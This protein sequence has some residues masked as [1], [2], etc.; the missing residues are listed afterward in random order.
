MD[1]KEIK[2]LYKFLKNTDIVELEVERDGG[3]VKMVRPGG[4]SGGAVVTTSAVPAAM[5]AQAAPST[6]TEQPSS[7]EAAVDD[8]NVKTIS[9]PMVGTFYRSPSPEAPSFVEMGTVVKK[10]QTLCILEAMKL[11]NEVDCDYNGK[12]VDILVEDGQPVEYGEPLF[13]VEVSK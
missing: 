11:M 9:S 5:S 7:K 10:G 1:I 4:V 8:E 2:A 13:K 6:A 12:V 3:R